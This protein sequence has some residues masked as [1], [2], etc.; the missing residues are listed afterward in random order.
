MLLG[1]VARWLAKFVSSKMQQ[2]AVR[3]PHAT[4]VP[5]R[6]YT[7]RTIPNHP[8]KRTSTVHSCISVSVCSR[9]PFGAQG[10]CR[11][12]T[13]RSTCVTKNPNHHTSSYSVAQSNQTLP[14]PYVPYRGACYHVPQ[15]YLGLAW[16]WNGWRVPPYQGIMS[17]PMLACTQ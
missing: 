2:A 8:R 4:F 12:V 7:C 16:T 3:H 10:T 17:L 5:T 13:S 11:I 6:T 15:I 14:W 1:W 9:S